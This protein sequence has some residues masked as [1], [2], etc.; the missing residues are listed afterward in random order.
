MSLKIRQA[1]KKDFDEIGKLMKREFSKPPFNE[2]DSI[3]SVLKSLNFYYKIGFIYIAEID[4]LI[5]GIIVFKI[6]QYWEGHVIIIEDLAIK[7]RYKEQGVGKELIKFV[8][9]YGKKKRIK[10]ILFTTH[11]ESKAVKFYVKLGY[12]LEKNRISMR[13]ILK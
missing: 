13:K 11:K 12:K 9:K 7:E 8:E 10:S 3:S 6:E 4:K 5:V 2:R 1:T